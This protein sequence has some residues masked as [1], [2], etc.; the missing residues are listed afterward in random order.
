MA[1]SSVPV[2]APFLILA[3]LLALLTSYAWRQRRVPGAVAL[4]GLALA[5]SLWLL[6]AALERNAMTLD[7]KLLWLRVQYLGIVLVP[8]A[9]LVF[10]VQYGARSGWFTRR[11]LGL[12]LIEPV[13]TLLL[14]WSNAFHGLVWSRVDLANLGGRAVLEL[15]YGPWF[16]V[17]AT[18]FYLSLLLGS[19]LLLRLVLLAR[20]RYRRQ[21]WVLLLSALAPWVGN[22]LFA[23]RSLAGP[24]DLTPFAFGLS[25]LL[26]AWSLFRYQLLAL[27]PLAHDAILLAMR[28]GVLVLDGQSQVLDMNPAAERALGLASSAARGRPVGELLQGELGRDAQ[29]DRREERLGEVQL[30]GA[31]GLRRYALHLAPLHDR[32]SLVA[33]RLMILS[34]ITERAQ[35][36]A[37]TAHL[38]AELR[39]SEQA[40]DAAT[41]AKSEFLANMSHEIRTPLT[42]VIGVSELLQRTRLTTEQAL[43]VQMARTSGK[44]LLNVIDDILDFSKIESGKLALRP[45][46]FELH[47]CLEEALDLIALTA[48]EKGLDLSYEIE[49]EVPPQWLGDCARL[50]QILLN[51][52][53][54]A[55]KFTAEGSV[56]LTVAA[57]PLG[58]RRYELRLAVADSGIGIPATRIKQLFQPFSQLEAVGGAPLRGTG[59]GL[60]LSKRL[61]EL[62]GG[63]MGVES[64][65]GGG[66]TFRFTVVMEALAPPPHPLRS[67]APELVGRRLLIAGVPPQSRRMLLGLAAD[68]GMSGRASASAEEALQLLD[69]PERPEL[70]LV[71]AGHGEAGLSAHAFAALL[72][73][74]FDAEALPLILLAS[75]H[76]GE[77]ELRIAREGFQAILTRPVKAGELQAVVK[78]LLL[79]QRPEG[80]PLPEPAAAPARAAE[81]ELAILLA[82]DDPT[83]QT[84]TMLLLE[85]L[86]YRATLAR[87]GEEGL[88][89]VRRA[90]YDIALLDVQMPGLDGPALAQRIRAELPAERQ[91]YLIALTANAMQGDRERYLSLGMD[92]YVSKPITLPRLAEALARGR[93]LR[94]SAGR[95]RAVGTVERASDS[96]SGAVSA[97]A[98]EAEQRRQALGLTSAQAARLWAR[99]IG[100]YLRDAPAQLAALEAGVWSHDYE[101]VRRAAHRLKSSSA[102]VGAGDLALRCDRLEQAAAGGAPGEIAEQVQQLIAAYRQIEPELAPLASEEG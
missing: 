45:A 75:F 13:L 91:P 19:L 53:S 28:D 5:T 71:G 62:M 52:L 89:A 70:A 88:A 84:L 41:R 9:W 94:A 79:D 11:R 39:A 37:N 25:A 1:L 38:L 57:R 29:R 48:G 32:S 6:T 44:A 34:D 24:L 16:W 92:D 101:L 18:W 51:L 40:A 43:L 99:V 68:W 3:A 90:P 97:A 81:D 22:T 4:G 27:V 96:P 56:C 73:Q 17:H 46:P 42:G 31:N 87:D 55:V 93:A 30:R 74:R 35:S 33:G 86:G 98:V 100:E 50:R 65:P 54:N 7:E 12:L 14:V 80:G 15:R 49:R 64:V 67:V 69:E 10:C 47:R 63:T 8:P 83:T 2:T 60:A 61:S 72:R 59:L 78:R 20:G 58:M 95:K 66:S 23:F 21:A 82:E 85:E 36:E 76:Q 77:P 26:L 102:I